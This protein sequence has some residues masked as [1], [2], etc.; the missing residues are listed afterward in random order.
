M[1][2]APAPR[3]QTS[4]GGRPRRGTHRPG[5]GTR[6]L[7]GRQPTPFD[8]ETLAVT[9]L[10][11]FSLSREAVGCGAASPPCP[12]GGAGRRPG[13]VLLREGEEPP[14]GWQT[15]AAISRG[16]KSR[17]SWYRARGKTFP[18][19]RR[20]IH[21]AWPR[22]RVSSL[23]PF[24]QKQD[25]RLLFPEE[26]PAGGSS[27]LPPVPHGAGSKRRDFPTLA[28]AR[29]PSGGG[30]FP[31]EQPPRCRGRGIWQLPGHGAGCSPYGSGRA[32]SPDEL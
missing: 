11:P 19:A 2:V 8:Q 25:Q 22:L 18:G 3:T 21:G 4:G 7:P 6:W 32:A 30:V 28:A 12:P 9:S 26:K 15:P 23:A 5:H 27:W 20:R 29:L 17:V 13:F 16:F 24:G 14:G 31:A 1:Q 10:G